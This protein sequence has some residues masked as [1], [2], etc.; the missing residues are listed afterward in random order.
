MNRDNSIIPPCKNAG[1]WEGGHARNE[2]VQALKDG[3]LVQWQA[4]SG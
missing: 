3:A 4:G 1:Y 2:A